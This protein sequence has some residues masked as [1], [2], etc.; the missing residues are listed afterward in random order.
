LKRDRLVEIGECSIELA[1]FGEA[2]AAEAIGVS[3]PLAGL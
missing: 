1:L 3:K 2:M